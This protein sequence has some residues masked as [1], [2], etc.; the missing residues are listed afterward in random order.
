VRTGYR[1]T[2]TYMSGQLSLGAAVAASGAAVSPNMGT[3]TPSASLAMLLA[4]LN[5]RLGFWAPSPHRTYWDLPQTRLWPYYLLWESLSQTTEVTSYCY[6]TDG[7]HFDNTGVYALVERGCRFIVLV[8]NGADPGPSFEDLGEAIRRC[9]TDFRAEFELDVSAFRKTAAY[10]L[11]GARDDHDAAISLHEPS[12]RRHFVVGTITYDRGHLAV[13]GR[14]DLSDDE[15][16]ATLVW[17]KPALAA[18]ETADVRQYA[19]ENSDFPQ[20]TTADQWFDEAQF[21]SYRKLGEFSAAIAFGGLEATAA[22][23]EKQQIE[24]KDVE[25]LF[26]ELERGSDRPGW[27]VRTARRLTNAVRVAWLLTPTRR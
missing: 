14:T 7:G 3:R 18:D 15:L 12:A 19:L 21:E 1:S 17:F 9:R 26:K 27:L 5:V 16:K 2:A 4:F 11:E 23:H 22:M 20:Q 25:L 8:D 10:R 6:L 24:A 13:L